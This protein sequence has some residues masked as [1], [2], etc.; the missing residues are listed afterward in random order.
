MTWPTTA[1]GRRNREFEKGV[2]LKGKEVLYRLNYSLIM[3]IDKFWR[4]IQ[5]TTRITDIE[6]DLSNLRN[7]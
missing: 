2:K 1:N 6:D 4:S 7:I 3:L 5:K